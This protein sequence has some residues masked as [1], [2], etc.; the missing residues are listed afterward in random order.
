LPGPLFG[1][2][3]VANTSSEGQPQG[4]SPLMNVYDYARYYEIAFGF[5]DF[6]KE[7]GFFEAA[8]RKFSGVEVKSVFELAAG[9][10]SHLEEWHRRGY[11][12]FGLEANREMIAYSRQRAKDLKADLTLFHGDM[13]RFALG[14]HKF[15]LAYVLVGS[16][17]VRTN[18]EFLSH[19]DSVAR[20]LR[21]GSLYLLDGVVRFNIFARSQERWTMKRGRITVRTKYRPELVDPLEQ[22]CID[23]ITLEINDHGTKLNLESRLARKAFFPQELLMLVQQHKRFEFL[24]WFTDFNLRKPKSA[25]GRPIVILR[26]R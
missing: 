13:K 6:E 15:E 19:L 20:V 26:K 23:D 9:P 24:G 2:K 5:R 18:A 16:L 22:T 17:F 1:K 12:Y 8:I 10:C 7:V 3:E 21:R 25:S 11:R 14:S 4:R